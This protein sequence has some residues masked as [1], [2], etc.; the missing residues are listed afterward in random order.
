MAPRQA[1]RSRQVCTDAQ[2]ADAPAQGL[3]RLW[4]VNRLSAV[5]NRLV[6]LCHCCAVHRVRPAAEERF[7][8]IS[9]AYDVLSDAT[10]RQ[11]GSAGRLA[12][13]AAVTYFHQQWQQQQQTLTHQHRA[14]T[15][16]QP[17]AIQ[18]HAADLAERL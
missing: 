9:E 7:K 6:P 5:L 13:M 2:P 11:V 17:L 8:E 14:C 15:T 10:K 12:G 16:H 3:L 1:P 18:T 4:R